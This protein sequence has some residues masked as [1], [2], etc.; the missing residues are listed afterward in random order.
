LGL[1]DT[2]PVAAV[3][4]VED[5]TGVASCTSNGDENPHPILRITT[6]N[7]SKGIRSR[8]SCVA[9]SHHFWATSLSEELCK[10]NNESAWKA[11]WLKR[12]QLFV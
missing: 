1:A 4:L 9:K 6:Y 2:G 8:T 3:T 5:G 7:W 12:W 10:L 11:V